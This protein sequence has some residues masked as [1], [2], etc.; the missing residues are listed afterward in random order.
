MGL[1]FALTDK[2]AYDPGWRSRLC[3]R[4]FFPS[5]TK[6]MQQKKP[7]QKNPFDLAK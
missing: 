1:V 7:S 6:E 4:G 5:S 3:E 2:D